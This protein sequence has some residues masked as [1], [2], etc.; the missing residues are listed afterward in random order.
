M[1]RTTI[2]AVSLS[3]FLGATL[4]LAVVS[5]AD[6]S[7][8]II[9]IKLDPF[10]SESISVTFVGK[11]QASAICVGKHKTFLGLYVYDQHG[12]CVAW[13]DLISSR[14]NKEQPAAGYPDALAAQWFPAEDGQHTVEVV[15]F[16]GVPT[17]EIELSVK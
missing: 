6:D 8:K 15:N 7:G 14:V 17:E 4:A 10:A 11:K 1:F 2:L 13:D 5:P 12:N 3:L 16:G 9:A